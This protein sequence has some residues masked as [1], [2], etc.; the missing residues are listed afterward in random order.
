MCRQAVLLAAGSGR[1]LGD[2]TDA[3]HKCLL[4][5]AGTPILD[6]LCDALESIGVEEL[7]VVTGHCRQALTT[8]LRSRQ[9]RL[10]LRFVHNHRYSESNN[11]VS[12]W[13]ARELIRPPFILVECDVF[14]EWPVLEP[15]LMP[16]TMIVSA[17]TERMD[18]TA[19]ELDLMGRVTRMVLGEQIAREERALL[20]KTVNLYS[21]SPA[22]WADHFL[23]TVCGF[24]E[25]ARV[26]SFYEAAL[27]S[28]INSGALRLTAIDVSER[29]W[30]EIDS[31]QD[32]VIA[33]T[34]F[35]GH[36]IE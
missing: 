26:D 29:K 30:I 11:I 20:K 24:I 23:P 3:S 17:Y 27:Q 28:S 5:V 16:D 6:N 1:R 15:L 21:F 18:G 8:H 19:V 33:E 2:R 10:R 7:V 22:S 36:V 12:L 25:A 34:M 9:S 35:A 31:P 14:M 32:L 13:C 4:E